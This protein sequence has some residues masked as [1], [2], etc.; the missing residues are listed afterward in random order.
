AAPKFYL[1]DGTD[2]SRAVSIAIDGEI[3]VLSSDG[4]VSR[5]LKGTRVSY[6]VA[7]VDPAMTDARRIRIDGGKYVH[8]LESGRIVRF[9]RK[10]GALVAQYSSDDLKGATDFVLSPDARTALVSVGNKVV[11]FGLPE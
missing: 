4:V 6:A 11:R 1:K 10:T 2:V 9:D 8:V 5:L 7:A 3:W